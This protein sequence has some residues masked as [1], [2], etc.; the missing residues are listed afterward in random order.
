M[1]FANTVTP[2]YQLFSPFLAAF[3]REDC[4]S[5]ARRIFLTIKARDMVEQNTM[6]EAVAVNRM[7][8]SPSHPRS[9]V[10]DY[11]HSFTDFNAALRSFGSSAPSLDQGP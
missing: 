6:T 10:S 5:N 2:I 1:P 7:F 4:S 3:S 8:I 9:I 11:P